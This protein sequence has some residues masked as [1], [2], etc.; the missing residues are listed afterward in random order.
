MADTQGIGIILNENRPMP[1]THALV[2]AMAHDVAGRQRLPGPRLLAA[3][4]SRYSAGLRARDGAR[5]ARVIPVQALIFWCF[6]L[7]R[8]IWRYASLHDLRRIL[9]GGRPLAA[10]CRP[11]AAGVAAHGRSVPR[12]VL[13]L[14]PLLLSCIMGGSRLAYRAWK[15]GRIARFDQRQRTPGA[16][17]GRGRCRRTLDPELAAQAASG[18]WSGCS[19]TTT[20]SRAAQIHG[21]TRAADRIDE[22][23]ARARRT[24]GV[25]AII[26]HAVRRAQRA[27]AGGQICA[28]QAGLQCDDRAV[29]RRPRE[30]QG[31]GLAAARKSSSTICS[32]AIRWCSTTRRLHGFLS[33]KTVH[34]HRRRRLDRRRAVPPDR[35]L[36][37]RELVLFELSEFALYQIEQEFRARAAGAA[38]SYARSAMQGTRCALTAG[39]AR[40]TGPQVVFHAA[41][42]KHVP[43]MEERNA[44]QAVQNNVLGTYVLAAARRATASKNSC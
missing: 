2:L 31:D 43:L 35:A 1:Q 39:V 29:L 11:R 44:W 10:V 23:C 40:S 41:A 4:Q 12:S 34:G 26:A 13:L 36:R 25:H 3:L 37:A 22:V 32:D 18:A 19:T 6:G 17:P 24:R 9:L 30:R 38:D 7:Y 33:G 8:G 20:R 27:A 5:I 15:E 42:Y 28:A 16:G 14:D 21:V